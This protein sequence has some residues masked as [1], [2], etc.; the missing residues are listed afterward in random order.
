MEV[1]YQG[2]GLQSATGCAVNEL[3]WRE[4]KGLLG[5]LIWKS[6]PVTELVGEE[7]ETAVDTNMHACYTNNDS[8]RGSE[9]GFGGNLTVEVN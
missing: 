4:G 1:G 6:D 9:K 8:E 5:S 3:Q 2:R 7:L